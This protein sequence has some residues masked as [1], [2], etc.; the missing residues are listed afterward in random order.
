MAILD[1]EMILSNAQAETT[2]A[3]H[4]STGYI[5]FGR[6]G[7]GYNKKILV[8]VNTSCSTA[9]SPTVLFKVQCDDN[10]SF[11]S[12]TDLFAT[13]AIPAATLVAG[14]KV[15]EFTLP[16]EVERY[17]QVTYT[18]GTAALTTGKFNA[19]VDDAQQ[20]NMTIM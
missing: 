16:A 13:A 10:S 12:A 3:A 19:W 1:N 17:V 6:A 5:D 4:A 20:T 11:S 15:L 2:V 7:A 18:I 9:S 14:Y 8:T